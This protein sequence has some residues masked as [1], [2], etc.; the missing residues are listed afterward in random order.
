MRVRSG[1]LFILACA[2]PASAFALTSTW[3]GT[4]PCN[5]TLQACIDAS[6]AGD[7]IEIATNTAIDEYIN[8]YNRSLTLTAA[9]GFKPRFVANRWISASTAPIAGNTTVTISG[10]TMTDG[11]ISVSY[12]G[13]AN[14]TYVLSDLTLEQT[15]PTSP[16]AY[17]RFAGNDGTINLK[18][19]NNRVTGSPM[20][21][22][23]G[24]IE[25]VNDGAALDAEI[26]YNHATRVATDTDGDGSG[27]YV[28]VT[29]G[30]SGMIKA[31]ANEVRGRFYRAGLFFSEGLFSSTAST[32]SVRAYNNVSICGAKEASGGQGIGFT[33]YNGTIN[34]Q[35]INNSISRCYGGVGASPWGGGS[36][37]TGH[38]DG[39]VKNNVIVA[40]SGLYFNPDVTSGITNDYNLINASSNS[41]ALGANTI[42]APARTVSDEVPRL[43]AG[44][45]AI[46]AADTTTLGLGIIFNALPTTDVDGLRRIV[47]AAAAADAD[48]GAYESGDLFLR[49]DVSTANT[50]SGSYITTIDSAATNGL[51]ATNV[52]TTQNF[53]A[54]GF[55]P[56][57][58]N[59]QP[60]GVYYASSRW[61]I[62]NENTL[63]PM[64]IGAHFNVFVPAPGGGVFRHVSTAANISGWT[65]MLD[66]SS[67]NDLPNRIV[68]ATQNWTAGSGVYNAQPIGV[69]YF[70][71]GGPGHWYVINGAQP[72]GADMP[73]NA[74]FNIYAQEASPNAFRVTASAANTSSSSIILD[75]PLLND[76]PC[77]QVNASRVFGVGPFAGNFDVYYNTGRW[78]LFLYNTGSVPAGTQFN[79]V[80][81]PE[82][83]FQC[84]DRIFADD[85]D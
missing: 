43:L 19:H 27:I 55:G 21:L 23:R 1:L 28:D 35:A 42:T 14:G 12:N 13:T 68:L 29:G 49:H 71:F 57:V 78:R 62:F 7:R 74:G 3:P 69:L 17:L 41:V 54:G 15:T 40:V 64:P 11:W 82:Q 58:A 18:M 85:F 61:K 47:G 65:T 51:S 36:P 5:T 22:N 79:V 72:D 4:T 34:A 39:L 6:A 73:A 30:G 32:Y 63:A 84:T 44:S 66:D 76:T 60:T 81:D 10:L 38:I 59:D 25:V 33:V 80:V 8:I 52:F 48:I 53:N 77:A 9:A 31:H 26:Y 83:V 16:P 50:T 46:D 75:H 20:D 37:A 45:P 2:L 24:L 67:V 56:S 70:A